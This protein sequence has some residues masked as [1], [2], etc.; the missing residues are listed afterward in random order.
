MARKTIHAAGGIVVRNGARPLIAVVQRAKDE[1]WVLPRGKLKL[2]ESALA[3]ARREVVEETGH[4]VRVREFLGAITYRARGRPKVVQFWH[5]QAAV[6][7]SRD[8]MKDI[9]AV[10]W[11]PLSAA[12]RRL[13]YPLEKLFLR[14]VG[15]EALR[16]RKHRKARGHATRAK[17]RRH[18]V[19]THGS[20]SRS[21]RITASHDRT[22]KI[23]GHSAAR[24]GQAN[25]LQRVLGRLTP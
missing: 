8:L 4:R 12:V 24:V 14:N 21:R 10:E 11:L 16:R 6:N 1:H 3:G 19:K 20:K 17:T 13:S 7:P 2:N 22:R 9:M 18:A 25:I 15:R 23:A 5:M